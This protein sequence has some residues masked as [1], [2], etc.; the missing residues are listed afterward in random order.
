[1]IGFRTGTEIV[2]ALHKTTSLVQSE[3]FSP[4]PTL[5]ASGEGVFEYKANLPMLSDRKGGNTKTFPPARGGI[6]GGENKNN[7]PPL[8]GGLR[9]GLKT[10]TLP[11]EQIK[12]GCL[13]YSSDQ[14]SYPVN[15]I[16]RKQYSGYIIGIVHSTYPETFW[17]DINHQ[18]L[19]KPRPRT[20]GG[21]RDWSASPIKNLAQRKKLRRNS[22]PTEKKLWSL[23]R[24]RQLGYK[25]RRQHPVGP[26]IV[27]F[28]SRDSHL[29]VEIDGSSHFNE[30]ACE[31]DSIRDSFMRSMGLNVLRFT[32]TDINSNIEEVCSIILDR[33]RM[34]TETPFES[35]WMHAGN[36]QAG[37]IMF[38]GID[39]KASLV[40]SVKQE[41]FISE[42]YFLDVD[43]ACSIITNSYIVKV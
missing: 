11:I 29:V 16:I 7:L 24:N 17:L 28:Y 42:M 30:D 36:I 38:S 2:V 43:N 40:K 33:C 4:S 21:N 6:K 27:D 22:T 9:G 12:P 5:P 1:M 19:I 3:T 26:Y 20:L 25:F 34:F 41:S 18:V 39:Y 31:Y 14:K 8:A 23:L 10:C 32:T 35:K 13:V 37:D 15:R